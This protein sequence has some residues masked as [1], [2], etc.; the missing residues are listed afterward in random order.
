MLRRVWIRA[1]DLNETF[2]TDGLIAASSSVQV[3][4][5]VE[6]ADGAFARILVQVNLDRLPIHKRIFGKLELSW[7]QICLRAML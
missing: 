1:L 4:G 3:R 5:I 6:E 2:G 7:G